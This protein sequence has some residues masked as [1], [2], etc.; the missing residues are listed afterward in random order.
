MLHYCRKGNY[1]LRVSAGALVYMAAVME[2][3]A[4][5]ILELAG[6]TAPDNKKSTIIP[7]HLQLTI[8]QV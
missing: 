3:L 4:A 5:K 8:R 7:R 6:N 1:A 2:Y